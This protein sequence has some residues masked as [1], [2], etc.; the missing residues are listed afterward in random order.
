MGKCWIV[1]QKCDDSR[2]DHSTSYTLLS[3]MEHLHAHL[4]RRFQVQWKTR[5]NPTF[6]ETACAILSFLCCFLG[7]FAACCRP[8]LRLVIHWV[9]E[10]SD[11]KTP[12]NYRKYL[13]ICHVLQQWVRLYLFFG[14]RAMDYNTVKSI[15][16]ALSSYPFASS[17]SLLAHWELNFCTFASVPC[18]SAY[19]MGTCGHT[20]N[21]KVN[22]D[23][24][25]IE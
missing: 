16:L 25:L 23:Y 13:I 20:S 21:K 6:C 19:R 17:L 15:R 12:V 10:W 9:G 3:N 5:Y 22:V 24:I 7:I 14:Q 18:Q 8:S 11:N 2:Q 1:S 4:H